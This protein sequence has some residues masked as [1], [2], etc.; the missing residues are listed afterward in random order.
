MVA[1]Q[2]KRTCSRYLMQEYKISERRACQL[3]GAHR[4]QVR[5]RARRAVDIKLVERIKAIAFEKRRFGYRR[6]HMML[7]REGIIVNHK[8]LYRLYYACGLKVRK[9]AGRKRALGLRGSYLKATKPNQKW[10][11]DFVHDALANGR[12]IRL[13]TIIDDYTRECLKIEVDTS[14]NG[15]RVKGALEEL[16]T[17]RGKPEII[18][19]DNGTEFTS[20]AML[21]WME[22]KKI[23]WQ[24]I[25]PGKPY[26]NGSIESFNGKLRD[27]CLN[28][29]WFLTIKEA[30]VRIEKWRQDYNGCR[31]HSALGGKTPAEAACCLCLGLEEIKTGTSN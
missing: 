3:V 2:A 14:L 4:S 24:Y 6:I 23:N 26:Q 22:E 21:Q 13:L 19:S 8:K 9:R 30:Q 10:S 15:K 31:P 12:K 27:E 7:K 16:I 29:N 25:Q 11:L 17:I 18:M 1:P 28:E 20:N 5:Y